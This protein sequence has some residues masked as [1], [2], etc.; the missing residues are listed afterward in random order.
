MSD[1]PLR[2]SVAQLAEMWGCSKNHVYNVVNRGELPC[3][4]VGTLLRFRREDVEAYEN[5]DREPVLPAP[6]PE[7]AVPPQAPRLGNVSARG[8]A[9]RL[10]AA[11][12]MRERGA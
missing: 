1:V 3:I 4:R 2:L 6:K 11:Q 9:A 10:R 5:R 7:V 8:Y 12:R